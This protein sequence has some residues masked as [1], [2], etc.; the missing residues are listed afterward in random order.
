MDRAHRKL[1]NILSFDG[2][3]VVLPGRAII[4]SSWAERGHDS[5]PSVIEPRPRIR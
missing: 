2:K 4:V 3:E 5:P 1:V